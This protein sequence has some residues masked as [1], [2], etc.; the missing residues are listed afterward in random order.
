MRRRILEYVTEQLEAPNEAGGKKDKSGSGRRIFWFRQG[1]YEWRDRRVLKYATERREEANEAGGKK[2]KSGTILFEVTILKNKLFRKSVSLF[3]ALLM[4]LTLLPGA[5]FAADNVTAGS[6]DTGAIVT[7]SVDNLLLSSDDFTGDVEAEEY[8]AATEDNVVAEDSAAAAYIPSGQVDENSPESFFETDSVLVEDGVTVKALVDFVDLESVNTAEAAVNEMLEALSG[9]YTHTEDDWAAVAMA[10]YGRGNSAAG[11]GIVNNA[12]DNYES[13]TNIDRS[14]IVLTALGVDAGNVFTGSAG[15]Y[16]DF[17]AQLAVSPSGLYANGGIYSLIALDSGAYDSLNRDIYVQFLLDS[18]DS[19]ENRWTWG[20]PDW[21]I[22]LNAEVITALAPYYGEQRVK[23]VVDQGLAFLS[24]RQNN[25]GHYGD[26]NSTAMVIVALAALGIDPAANTGAFAKEGKSLIDGLLMF[27]TE[28][29]RFGWA[30]NTTPNDLATQQGFR[31]LVAY[32]GFVITGG[33]YNIYLF[34][35]QTGDGSEL[36]GESDPGI[37]PPDPGGNNG[38]NSGGDITVYFTLQGL[39]SS[40]NSE[41]WVSNRAVSIVS[42]ASVSDVIVKAIFE[43]GYTQ[44]GAQSGFVTSVTTPGGFTLSQMHNGMPDSGWLYK[45]NSQLPTVG[46]DSYSLVNGDRV[47]LYF[48]KD[49][50]KDPDAGNFSGSSSGSSGDDVAKDNKT[51]ETTTDLE[52]DDAST[53]AATVEEKVANFV[54]IN[55]FVD[56]LESDWFFEAVEYA[57]INNLMKGTAADQFSPGY[58]TTRAMFVT[59]LWRFD[60]APAETGVNTFTDVIDG[61]WYTDAVLWANNRGIAVGYGDGLF[62]SEDAITREQAVTMLKSYAQKEDAAEYEKADLSAFADYGDISTW[63]LDGML[64]A[65][66]VGMINGRDDNI[67]APAAT[68]TRAEMATMFMRFA[69]YEE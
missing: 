66:S 65:V 34:G 22:D 28:S 5:A 19:G 58:P 1:G 2:D 31:A 47:L 52:I 55:P 6:A 60:G 61:Q 24:E 17:T 35:P 69:G 33:A 46:M 32:R 4:L 25:Q 16:L 64:W 44:S 37:A 27:R 43:A 8:G 29:D 53:P 57:C 12:R 67:L 62:G 68:S 11:A 9:Y 10:A 23:T 51:P 40:N 41:T 63:A 14:I 48:T 15:E 49:W 7:S 39:N 42:G 54:W 13:I 26:A 3:L 50:T 20:N 30:D 21:D 18:F 59:V 38:G 56:V 45:V 36:T